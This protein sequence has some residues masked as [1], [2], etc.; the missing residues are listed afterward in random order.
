M[1][2]QVFGLYSEGGLSINAIA[3]WLNDHGTATRNGATRW[4]RSVVWAMLRNP[5]L[6][7]IEEPE[8]LLDD[9]SKALLED[10]YNRIVRDRTVLFL[11]SRLSTVKRVDRIILLHQGKVEAIGN[12]TQLLKSS[13]LYRHWE[14]IRF[15]EFRY[16]DE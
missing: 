1:V 11:P 2:R 8:V 14:Y 5:A 4:C 15:N 9:D 13:P 16:D 12:H 3:R 10:A 7:I 6:M